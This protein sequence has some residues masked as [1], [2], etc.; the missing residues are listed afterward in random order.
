MKGVA[1]W[2]I[3]SALV[4]GALMAQGGPGAGPVGSGAPLVELKG[5]VARVQI[6]PGEGMPFVTVSSGDQTVKVYLGSMRYLMAQGFNPKLG[7]AISV[8]AFKMGGDLVAVTVTLPDANKTIRLRDDNGRPL[9][10]GGPRGP[11]W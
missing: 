10:R 1:G 3:V 6:T 7:D 8:K 5:K 9:W 4:S 11:R 2:M